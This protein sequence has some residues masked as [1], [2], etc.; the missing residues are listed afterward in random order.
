M[1]IN[2]MLSPA[3][4]RAK[5]EGSSKKRILQSLANLF[6]EQI[7][8][9]DQDKLFQSLLNRERLGSTGI[10]EGIAIPHCR[11]DTGGKTYAACLSLNEPVDFDAIDSKPVDIVFAMLVPEEAEQAH[12]ETLANLAE[13]MHKQPYV[14]SLR[15]A[16]TD[17]QLYD[18]AV[19]PGA[20]A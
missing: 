13:A 14:A 19:T 8:G 10:G 12:L 3:R 11:F 5:V 1:L 17:S 15:E 20:R 2:A 6:A 9:L 7:E 4:T 16:D 18:A